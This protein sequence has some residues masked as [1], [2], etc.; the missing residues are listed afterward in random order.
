MTYTGPSHNDAGKKIKPGL[1]LVPAIVLGVVGLVTMFSQGAVY[2]AEPGY[3]YL[4]QYPDGTQVGE[5]TPGYHFKFWGTYEPFK[6]FITVAADADPS[7]DAAVSAAIPPI[8]GRFTD[9]VTADVEVTARFQM[10]SVEADFLKMAIAYR[11]QDNLE[12]STLVP[13]LKEVV[14]NAARTMTA[15]DYI[16]GKGG[17]F[18]NAI[19]DQLREGTYIL[20]IKEIKKKDSKADIDN[21]DVDRG[22]DNSQMVKYEVRKMRNADGTIMRKDTALV[23]YKILVSQ[24]N[25]SSVDPEPKFK[26]MLGKQRD[27]AAEA[28][29]KKQEAKRAEYE[30]QKIIAEGEAEKARI[31]VDEEKKQITK[32][33][34]AETTLKQSKIDLE[35]AK[36]QKQREVELA[37]KVKI[38][39]DAEAYKKKKLVSAGASPQELLAAAVQMNKDNALAL[40][41]R[42]VPTNYF[43]GSAGAGGAGSSYDEE[44]VRQ[45][46]M[47]NVNMLKDLGI[48]VKQK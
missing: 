17:E 9:A 19:L 38:A 5:V 33:I 39:A 30:K 48:S 3:N 32:L 22:V 15:Q 34:E 6:K 45:L 31:Q 23:D 35:D 1:G 27:A 10:P 42:D 13:V 8:E 43:A 47:M 36:I 40:A 24:S 25:V 2:Y 11:T 14:R 7:N 20:D 41:N 12:S 46:K 21:V 44:M 16:A 29:V 37:E 4:V 28:S 26:D 18:E